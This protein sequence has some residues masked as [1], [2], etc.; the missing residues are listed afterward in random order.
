MRSD[1]PLSGMTTPKG[2][3][4]DHL[5]HLPRPIALD[6][7]DVLVFNALQAHRSGV[8]V[9]EKKPVEEKLD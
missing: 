5:L 8:M 1:T 6:F 7:V 4:K 2:R 3:I 9:G